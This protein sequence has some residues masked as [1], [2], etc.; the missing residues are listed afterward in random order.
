M[1]RVGKE[2]YYRW[3]TID[4]TLALHNAA[5][6]S[7][8]VVAG[9]APPSKWG[10]MDQWERMHTAETREAE[11]KN[12]F[13]LL[14][15]IKKQKEKYLAEANSLTEQYLTAFGPEQTGIEKLADGLYTLHY[16]YPVIVSRK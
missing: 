7:S 1:G 10:T 9:Y 4:E 5:G 8:S 14:A 6:F 12:N 11:N 13:E 3:T 16:T 2:Q 15:K